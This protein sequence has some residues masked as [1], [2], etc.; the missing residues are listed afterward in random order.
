MIDFCIHWRWVNLPTPCRPLRMFPRRSQTQ[1]SCFQLSV[2]FHQPLCFSGAKTGGPGGAHFI[3]PHALSMR[4]GGAGLD[5]V[6]LAVA[7]QATSIWIAARRP[8]RPAA[9]GPFSKRM[10]EQ[11]KNQVVWR[12]GARFKI[13]MQTVEAVPSN[14]AN[15]VFGLYKVHSDPKTAQL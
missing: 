10:I 7:N 8:A 14:V 3:P 15:V 2:V 9:A 13:L 4:G 11:I 6:W 1:L 12:N 5:H